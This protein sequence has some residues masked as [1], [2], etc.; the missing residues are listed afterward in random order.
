MRLFSLLALV[1]LIACSVEVPESPHVAG[2]DT[3]NTDAGPGPQDA[4]PSGQDVGTSH[5]CDDDRLE[6]NDTMQNSRSVANAS[7]REL[8]ACGGNE[9]W[10]LLELDEG[11]RVKLQLSHDGNGDI[12]MQIL[13]QSGEFITSVDR[14]DRTMY[15]DWLNGHQ[16][17]ACSKRVH[18]RSLQRAYRMRR[19]SL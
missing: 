2:A 4:G 3:G 18:D 1:S 10:F 13:S 6:P 8:V 16:S 9:D 5:S 17:S 19:R 7:G 14:R 12:N 15:T 11:E